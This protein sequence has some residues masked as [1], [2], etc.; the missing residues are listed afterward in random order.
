MS[1]TKDKSVLV[2]DDDQKVRRMLTR[3][4]EGE[5]FQVGEAGDGTEMRQ[6]LAGQTYD[7]VLLDVMLPGEDGLSLMRDIRRESEIPVIMIT[8]KGD[9]VDRVA[10]LETGA[11]DYI[12]KPFHLREV[13]A[14]VR[15]VLR[16]SG[17]SPVAA[18][19]A[20]AEP[21]SASI[22]GERF[23]FDGWLLDLGR[24]ALL[25]PDG[26][27][28]TLTGGEFDLLATFA[29]SPN[30]PLSRDQLMDRLKGHDWTPFDRSIDT[31]VGRLRKKIE[32]DPHNPELIKTLR[33]VGYLFTPRVDRVP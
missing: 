17:D 28:V 20:S 26:E 7:L 22:G 9:L 33:G 4:L 32:K 13:L 12:A 6:A 1:E 23:A 5:G 16:R 2:V 8:G 31:Q 19:E 24:R 10:G 11:D 3:Y 15:S 25:R 18:V 30:R 14:R 21:G 29:A 27:A